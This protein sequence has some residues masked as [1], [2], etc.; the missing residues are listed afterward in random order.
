[1]LWKF[2][3]MYWEECALL[4]ALVFAVGILLIP[5]RTILYFS[6]LY[7][8]FVAIG[9]VYSVRKKFQESV[10]EAEW[11]EQ[12]RRKDS[13]TSIFLDDKEIED[14]KHDV[15]GIAEDAK[16]FGEQ[17]LNGGADNAMIF[18]L[19]AA[20]GSG[21]SSFLNLSKKQVW[22]TKENKEKV[23]VFTFRPILFDAR[24]QDIA[25]IFIREFFSF[26]KEE[27][28]LS[29]RL[30]SDRWKLVRLISDVSMGGDLFGI[31][32]RVPQESLDEVLERI[33][34]EIK[35][36]PKKII[37]IVDDL[38]RLYVEEVKAILGVVRNIFFI[39]KITFV[40]CYDTSNINSFEFQ[41]KVVHTESES[42]ATSK[43]DDVKRKLYSRADHEPDSQRINAYL[44][45][46]VQVKKTL[47]PDRDKLWNFF[48][49]KV[50]D[51]FSDAD[52]VNCETFI[53]GIK[54]FFQEEC[55]P[56]Y[57]PYLGDIRKIKRI[58]NFIRISRFLKLM[59]KD[60]RGRDISSKYL[61][62]F[63]LIY[64]NYPHIFRKIYIEETSGSSGFFSVIYCDKD[65][66]D[67][68]PAGFKN[69]SQFLDFLKTVSEEQR[70]LLE[71]LFRV[72][73]FDKS[74]IFERRQYE[75]EMEKP[76]FQRYSPLFNGG[77][78][79]RINLRDYLEIVYEGKSI[80]I[81]LHDNFHINKIKELENRSVQDIFNATPEY[82][83]DIG[84]KSRDMFFGKLRT[85]D[86]PFSSAEK[87]IEY[88]THNL[89]HYSMISEFSG[90]YE[91]I[92][93]GLVYRLLWMLELRGW[94]DEKRESYEN[95]D[96]NIR[97]LA[98][99]ILGNEQYPS[100]VN[101]LFDS[102]GNPILAV[103]D[104]TK[105]IYAC[106]GTRSSSLF[107]VR[108]SLENYAKEHSIDVM[109]ALSRKAFL[110]FHKRIISEKKNFLRDI[111]DMD[112]ALL[113]G[114][115]SEAIWKKFE[116]KKDGLEEEVAKIK[117]SLAS[118]LLF[119]FARDEERSMGKYLFD[120]TKKISEVMREYLLEIC[121][122]VDADMRNA[123]LFLNFALAS[124][125]DESTG[126]QEW[127]PD[128]SLLEKTLGPD[129]LRSY[130]LERGEVIKKCG[131][132]LALASP[133][134]KVVTYNYV[135]T[136][137]K[138]MEKL[139]EKLDER[140]LKEGE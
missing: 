57:A 59:K 41:K 102:G 40:L 44:E 50:R 37:V 137:R 116:E 13:P 136:Y 103:N 32:F 48:E 109:E 54:P 133:D 34:N 121:F 96:E 67:C 51:Y 60:M 140:F 114:D 25:E 33:R 104:A 134:K 26:L 79:S 11:G 90:V 84:E 111:A 53:E 8:S 30:E 27:R 6:W 19:D 122:N 63:I 10:K 129:R 89:S 5:Q 69:S 108:R 138:D 127:V 123:E 24:K 91:G 87:V 29:R 76:K 124:F 110:F 107:N 106:T 88:I 55:Y 42:Y 65:K 3:R 86:V 64:I 28:M 39:P 43:D 92:R 132:S 119:R 20:W 71:E 117:N 46:I 101:T 66:E 82:G 81:W 120:D 16:H 112:E 72:P 1:M 131:R 31:R 35:K 73:I 75:E 93:A 74:E 128:V 78:F 22:E 9:I 36:L 85:K 115:F 83:A 49:K 77:Y 94:E 98:E 139:F 18:G 23:A 17:V 58:L 56:K 125:G 2:L 61:F 15:L 62:Q 21:K 113:L 14:E 80:D 52:L 38:D 105:L 135:A 118:A 99:K 126:F 130:W 95:T 45:K 7:V 68:T 97:V 47:I 12:K 100:L 70:F 4:V